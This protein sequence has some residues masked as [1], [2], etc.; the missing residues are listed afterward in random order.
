MGSIR[1]NELTDS[2]IVIEV[3]EEIAQ[4]LIKDGVARRRYPHRS[5]LDAAA[6]VLAAGG[7]TITLAQGPDTFTT[8]ARLLTAQRRDP[9]ET[10]VRLVR[11][12]DGAI[13]LEAAAEVDPQL[14][15]GLLQDVMEAPTT[16]ASDLSGG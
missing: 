9:D 2:H 11:K 14:L 4:A 16:G 5:W 13:V 10:V 8:L 7:T 15:A 1:S 12:N 6:F 3:P